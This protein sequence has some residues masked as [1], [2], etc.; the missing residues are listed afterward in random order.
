[1]AVL[2]PDMKQVK[3]LWD[4]RRGHPTVK[5]WL[6]EEYERREALEL[7]RTYRAMNQHRGQGHG[8]R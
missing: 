6:S 4:K 7:A 1:V 5:A 2:G 3:E 8:P